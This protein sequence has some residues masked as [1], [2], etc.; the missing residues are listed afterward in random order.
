MC[1]LRHGPFAEGGISG[2]WERRISI[3]TRAF[4]DVKNTGRTK[5]VAQPLLLA[6]AAQGGSKGYGIDV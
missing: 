4:E 1:W 3:G 5:I 2:G 6:A